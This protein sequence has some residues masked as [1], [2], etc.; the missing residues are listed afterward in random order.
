LNFD[1][2]QETTAF[3]MRI[4]LLFFGHRS[5]SVLFAE[6]GFDVC[7]LKSV[8]AGQCKNEEIQALTNELLDKLPSDPKLQM[9]F[10]FVKNSTKSDDRQMKFMFDHEVF[11]PTLI[12]LAETKVTLMREINEAIAD[13]EKKLASTEEEV[14]FDYSKLSLELPEN[15][16]FFKLGDYYIE[17]LLLRPEYLKTVNIQLLNAQMLEYLAAN[18][19]LTQDVDNKRKLLSLLLLEMQAGI[20]DPQSLSVLFGFILNYLSEDK[21]SDLSYDMKVLTVEIYIYL[22]RLHNFHSDNEAALFSFFRKQF[23]GSFTK[24]NPQDN[25]RRLLM[26]YWHHSCSSRS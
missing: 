23:E 18:G 16:T 4:L 7:I 21:F 11:F 10:N 1:K 15:K 24:N 6:R 22:N 8:L 12:I 5:T 3:K 9:Y 19:G 26:K 25:C 14:I 20:A 2:D 17:V 13:H